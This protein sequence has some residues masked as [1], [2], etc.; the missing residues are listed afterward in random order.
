MLIKTTLLQRVGIPMIADRFIVASRT[1][2]IRGIPSA[3]ANEITP[4]LSSRLSGPTSNLAINPSAA[5]GE[6]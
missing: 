2:A 1:D 4:D 3:R 6:I 5:A